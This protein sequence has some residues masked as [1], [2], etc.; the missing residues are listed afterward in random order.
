MY[1]QISPQ[2]QQKHMQMSDIPSSIVYFNF[3]NL[4]KFVF[5]YGIISEKLIYNTS[6][7]ASK[8]SM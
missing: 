2:V 6:L 4:Y 8:V 7:G 3:Q 5:R 1:F